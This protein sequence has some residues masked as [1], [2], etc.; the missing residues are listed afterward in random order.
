MK[1]PSQF[2]KY[3]IPFNCEVLCLINFMSYIYMEQWLEAPYHISCKHIISAS[4][5]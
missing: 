1:A 4:V 3:K 5:R 2:Q